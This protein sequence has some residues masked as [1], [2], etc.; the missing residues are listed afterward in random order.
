MSSAAEKKMSVDEFFAWAE[1]REGR[2]ELHDGHP[3]AMSPERV[4]HAETKGMAFLALKR[5]IERAGVPCRAVPDG[6]AVRIAARTAFEPDA[7]VYCG[8]RL[9][10]QAIEIPAPVIVVEVLSPSTEGR[11]HRV[12]LRGYFS[13]PSVQHYLILDPDTRTLIRHKRGQGDIIETR[14]LGEGLLR[15]EPPSIET[16]V[17]DMFAP[18]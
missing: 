6:A 1:G 14:I 13:L 5:A 16:A 12:K 2:W 8:P 15:L 3:V 17:A 7:T 11:D 4:L 18:L 9:P 10:P